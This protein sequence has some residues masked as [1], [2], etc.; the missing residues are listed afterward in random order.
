MGLADDLLEIDRDLNH[1]FRGLPGESISGTIGRAL[2][3]KV[4]WS[5]LAAFPVDLGAGLIEAVTGRGHCWRQAETERARR[6][7]PENTAVA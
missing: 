5:R 3:A 6:T 1:D 7:A 4:W 2:M